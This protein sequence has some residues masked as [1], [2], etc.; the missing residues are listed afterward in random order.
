MRENAEKSNTETFYA[1]MG[2]KTTG[3][4]CYIATFKLF[5]PFF[6]VHWL[7]QIK[8]TNKLYYRI[9]LGVCAHFMSAENRILANK[10]LV[11]CPRKFSA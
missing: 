10:Y 1:V 2:F 8:I 7:F 4:R 9:Y 11:L 5:N 3:F 6:N